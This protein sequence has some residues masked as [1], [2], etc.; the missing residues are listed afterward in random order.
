[1]GKRYFGLMAIWLICLAVVVF[2]IFGLKSFTARRA[3]KYRVIVTPTATLPMRY[4]GHLEP[5]PPASAAARWD[6]QL[7]Y[8]AAPLSW[9]YFQFNA[10]S[11]D[12]PSVEW[13]DDIR[14]INPDL[15]WI[16][17]Q[18]RIYPSLDNA[19]RTNAQGWV[20]SSESPESRHDNNTYTDAPGGDTINT[21]DGGR[22][23]ELSDDLDSRPSRISWVDENTGWKWQGGD[24]DNPARQFVN[25]S[26]T[27]NGGDIW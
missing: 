26:R 3:R 15:G 6:E 5:P 10:S 18:G 24:I 8:T 9:R 14:F 13:N 17:S 16:R 20:I 11:F 27:S 25:I 12:S 1:M 21:E 23:W 2:I 4:T 7:T 19:S 22:T